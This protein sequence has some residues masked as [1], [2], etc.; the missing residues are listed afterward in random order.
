MGQQELKI[1]EIDS[2]LGAGTRGASL[3]IGALKTAAFN[4]QVEVFK[5]NNAIQLETLN[6]FI[7]EEIKTPNA[8]RIEHISIIYQRTCDTISDLLNQGTYPVVLSGDHSTAGGTI[9]GIK[10]AYPNKRLGVVW[11]DAHADLHT[12]YTTPSGNVHGM[13]LATALQTDN[14]NNKRNNPEDSTVKYWNALKNCGYEGQKLAPEDLILVAV[15]DTEKEENLLIEELGI[16]NISVNKIRNSELSEIV[17]HINSKLK[18]CDM[19]YVSFDVDSMDCN[20]VSHGTGTPVPDG[21]TPEEAEQLITG[22]IKS[23]KTVCFE[24]VEVNPCLDEKVNTMA[25]TAV[26]ILDKT[27]KAIENTL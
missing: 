26:V 25:E 21:L 23:N 13:P 14:L 8:K 9:S 12:P 22:I 27:I 16:E 5:K 18:D 20:L 4:K 7:W 17:N 1:I 15:R 24:L 2:E 3:G 19:I 6:Q 10:K 11:I